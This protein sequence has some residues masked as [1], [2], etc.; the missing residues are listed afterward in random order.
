MKKIIKKVKGF[1]SKSKEKTSKFSR[2]PYRFIT[3]RWGPAAQ[4]NM[5]GGDR[6]K[7]TVIMEQGRPKRK[8]PYA[9]GIIKDALQEEMKMP[10]L[11]ETGGHKSPEFDQLSEYM[12]AKISHRYHNL[13]LQ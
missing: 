13:D 7:E 2:F 12:P 3:T 11:D 5:I 10:H 1:F 8:F 9:Q 4:E 6:N